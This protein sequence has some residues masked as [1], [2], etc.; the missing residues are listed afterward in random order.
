MGQAAQQSEPV[1]EDA[2]MGSDHD[3]Q[4][5]PDDEDLVYADDDEM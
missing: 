1:L 3:S 4:S 5:Q 2:P